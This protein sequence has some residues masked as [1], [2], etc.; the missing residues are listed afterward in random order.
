MD[1][2]EKEGGPYITSARIRTTYSVCNNTLRGFADKGTVRCIRIG[3]GGKRLYSLPDVRKALGV[4]VKAGPFSSKARA[5]VVYA[6]V[7]S[8]KQQPDLVRQREALVRLYPE[9]E[10][11]TDI[12][13]GINFKRRGLVSILDRAMRGELEEVVVAHRDRLCRIAFDLVEHVLRQSG[14]RLVVLDHVEETGTDGESDVA[15]LQE[16]LLAIAT[17]FVAS[18]NGK[19]AARNRRQRREEAARQAEALGEK[20]SQGA[21]PRRSRRSRRRRNGHSRGRGG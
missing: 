4:Q 10:V 12:A 16:D 15:E 7:S 14:V 18:N 20:G 11:V 2:D 8:K 21:A 3:D 13:S 5:K 9:P 1:E 17:V 19:R 6:R